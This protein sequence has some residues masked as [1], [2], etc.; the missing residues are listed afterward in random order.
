[1]KFGVTSWV[2]VYPFDPKVIKRVEEM[3]F[4]GIEIPIEDP[5]KID[6]EKIREILRSSRIE[7][8][9][10]C[11]VM[12]PKRDLANDDN[13]IRENG[14]R[15][16]RTC[17]DF[18]VKFDSE[19]VA[20][21]IYSSVGPTLGMPDKNKEWRYAVEG[22]KELGK[23][24][25][26]RGVFLAIEPLNRYETH[27]INTVSECLKLIKEVDSPALKV[28][29]DTY[30]ANIEEKSLGNAI[31]QCGSLLYHFHSCENDRGTPGSGHIEW[32]EA[33]KALKEI[34]YNRYMVI[35]T[36]QHGIKEIATAASIWRPLAPNQDEIARD[37]LNFLK[38]L[39]T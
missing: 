31:R 24:A 25:E 32:N 15:Y 12:S 2:W 33:A 23:Y 8:S 18:S 36:F 7:C 34:E 20:G 30:H 29:F 14:K 26:D 11:A 17:I 10:I 9:S 5:S 3:G 4:D 35:E 39:V 19:I 38:K 21:P 1:M 22:L 16:V 28:H 6:G 27:L 37:G 13:D